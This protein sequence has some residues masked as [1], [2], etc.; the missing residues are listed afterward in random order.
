MPNV[1]RRV[2]PVSTSNLDQFNRSAKV[3]HLLAP[4]AGGLATRFPDSSMVERAAVNR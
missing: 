2:R 1:L 3:V 4:P